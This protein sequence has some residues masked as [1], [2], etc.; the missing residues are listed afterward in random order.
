MLDLAKIPFR[1][2]DRGEEY[3]IIL[4]GGPCTANPEPFAPFFDV[5]IAGEGEEADLE[6]LKIVA[7]GKEKGL[8]KTEILKQIK[9]VEGAYVPALHE[10]GEVVVKAV[11]RD[12]ENAESIDKPLVPVIETVH[13]RAQLELYRGCA[14]G[15]RFCQAGYWYRP[16]R[17]RSAEKCFDFAKSMCDSAGFDE[18]SLC[19]LS[20]SDYTDLEKLQGYLEPYCH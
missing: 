12:F 18:I 20:T 17:E 1:A 3:P 19:S 8:T 11:I 10:K 6:V 14:S 9:S 15:C 2:K 13:D 7:D 4:A 16:I 5:I